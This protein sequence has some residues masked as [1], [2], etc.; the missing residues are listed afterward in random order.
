MNDFTS[1]MTGKTKSHYGDS[2]TKL[3]VMDLLGFIII[4]FFNI[5]C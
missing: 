4:I 1:G 2:L 5:R 3:C